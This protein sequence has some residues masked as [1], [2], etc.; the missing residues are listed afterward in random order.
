MIIKLFIS[1]GT[2]VIANN[3]GSSDIIASFP[4]FPAWSSDASIINE[5]IPKATIRTVTIANVRRPLKKVLLDFL[6]VFSSSENPDTFGS[7]SF[8]TYFEPQYL[9]PSIKSDI[10]PRCPQFGHSAL[11]PT[12]FDFSKC[13]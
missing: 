8:T 11:S 12:T 6:P 9:Q 1:A 13:I 7:K 2:Y 4:S 10:F 5:T 3:P